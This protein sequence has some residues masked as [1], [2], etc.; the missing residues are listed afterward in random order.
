MESQKKEAINALNL[1]LTNIDKIVSF[2]LVEFN[3]LKDNNHV[4][5]D[6]ATNILDN[7]INT[8]K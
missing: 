1:F 6:L 2:D 3:P 7:I 4:T 8:L 5:Y